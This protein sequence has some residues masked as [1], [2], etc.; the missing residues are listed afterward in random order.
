M[1]SLSLRYNSGNHH[2]HHCHHHDDDNNRNDD[3]D[4]DDDN[5][6]NSSDDDD[7]NDDDDV[8]DPSTDPIIRVCG[9]E[10]FRISVFMSLIQL[11][12]GQRGATLAVHRLDGLRVRRPNREQ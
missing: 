4:D 1:G 12:H 7:D 3:D 2:H 8:D 10:A 6:I 5:D 9:R 11:D